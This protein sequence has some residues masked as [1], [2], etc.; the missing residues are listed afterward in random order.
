MKMLRSNN[1]KESHWKWYGSCQNRK[2][3]S[4][5]SQM[6]KILSWNWLQ[7]NYIMKLKLRSNF[8]F[9]IRILAPICVESSYFD[10]S[11]EDNILMHCSTD[12]SWAMLHAF[13]IRPFYQLKVWSSIHWI[14]SPSLVKWHDPPNPIIMLTNQFLF[15]NFAWTNENVTH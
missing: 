14:S 7:W 10:A 9:K 4:N 2:T 12:W 3:F 6:R 1:G 5:G 13:S 8:R 15:M 11:L